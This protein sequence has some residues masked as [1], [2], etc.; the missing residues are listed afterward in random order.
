MYDFTSN[1][2]S[3]RNSNKLKEERGS[4]ARKAFDRFTTKD[5]YT[6]VCMNQ[7]IEIKHLVASDLPTA[8][9]GTSHI[10]RKVLQC[11]T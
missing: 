10:I 5:S 4:C 3:H 6:F 8:T 7:E 2:Q 1:N 11:E 9:I